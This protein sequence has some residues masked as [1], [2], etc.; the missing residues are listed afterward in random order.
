MESSQPRFRLAPESEFCR[1]LTRRLLWIAAGILFAL[2]GSATAQ[3]ALHEYMMVF[4]P[5]PSANAVGYTLHIGQSP[6]EYDVD[7]DLGNPGTSEAGATIHYSLELDDASDLFV[8]LAAYDAAGSSSE[9]SNEVRVSAV[10]PPPP[11]PEPEPEPQP[12]PEPEPE[13]EPQPDPEPEP[14]PEPQ[15]DPE[16]EPEPEPEP[17]PAPSPAPESPG[18]LFFD[19]FED[20]SEGANAR[21]WL[22]TASGNALGEDSKLFGV[23]RMPDGGLGLQTSS[24]ESNIHS[25]YATAAS[26][27]W[28]NY[29]YTG[30]MR[31]DDASAGIGVT[32]LSDY[33][34]SDSYLRLRRWQGSPTFNLSP[35]ADSG[36]TCAGRTTT[37]VEPE[38]NVWYRFRF[39]AV[40]FEGATRVLARVWDARTPEP[41]DWP[42]DCLWS[43]WA[44]PTGRPGVWSMGSGRKMWDDLAA[45]QLD[46]AATGPV[47]EE[48][49]PEV[50]APDESDTLY[51]EDFDL[52]EPGTD[53]SGWVDTR[54][55]NSPLI[56]DHLFEVAELPDG[57]RAF[58]TSSTDTNIHSHF[59]GDRANE[60]QDYEY[61][62]RMQIS[63]SDG[64]IGITLYSGYPEA[65]EYVR[66]RR[67]HRVPEFTLSN[68]DSTRTGC[69]GL[70]KTG[71]EPQPNRWYG[72][73]A[74]VQREE[75]GVRIQARVWDELQVE[76]SRWQVDC[77]L[78][79]SSPAADGGAP[80]VWSMGKGTKYWDNLKIEALSEP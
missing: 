64:G 42:I 5:S 25:H 60:W 28:W 73:R 35:H 39:R 26:A 8:A 56:G 53:P 22:D 45:T 31:I 20:E 44:E 69:L 1:A 50:P 57:E 24:T 36:Q 4:D 66:I 37:S 21:D 32:M 54:R 62:G 78:P 3:A 29:E 59:L 61:S 7:F 27:E 33:P 63:S 68:H 15:P 43:A 6:G 2:G 67:F 12:D 38:P 46:P 19:D 79:S 71:V 55:R 17:Q 23:G 72:F 48:P 16:P 77:H 11:A 13:P 52:L 65:N 18:L 30:R 34:N 41:E 47:E 74:R 49:T 80:G 75:G 10:V 9:F 76:P 58:A 40:D 14:E 51:F 70:K